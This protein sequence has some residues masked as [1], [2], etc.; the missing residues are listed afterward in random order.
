M[1]LAHKEVPYQ[2]SSASTFKQWDVFLCGGTI[3]IA[4]NLQ[5]VVAHKDRERI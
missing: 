1:Q 5:S 4:T 3:A 2:V